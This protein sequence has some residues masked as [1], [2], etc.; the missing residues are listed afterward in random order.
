MK[1]NFVTGSIAI[2][3][4]LMDQQNNKHLV[5]PYILRLYSSFCLGVTYKKREIRYDS[6]LYISNNMD[7]IMILNINYV[8]GNL[9]AV[10]PLTVAL[11]DKYNYSL[12]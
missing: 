1:Q 4:H 5:L 2:N 3:Y 10:S 7:D 11:K 12:F 6:K 8:L 9:D